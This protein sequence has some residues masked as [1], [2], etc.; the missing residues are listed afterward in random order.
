M[1]RCRSGVPS[2]GRLPW[3]P[4]MYISEDT[5]RGFIESAPERTRPALRLVREEAAVGSGEVRR[6]GAQAVVD[7]CTHSARPAAGGRR[8][9]QLPAGARSLDAATRTPFVR[10]GRSAIA[11]TAGA[12]AR[13]DRTEVAR[14]SA[15]EVRTRA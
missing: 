3:P 13:L 15:H 12:D 11:E 10:A 14:T 7:L 6:L 5:R 9:P 4:S 1:L 8:L 2:R